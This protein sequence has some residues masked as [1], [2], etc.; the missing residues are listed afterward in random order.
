MNAIKA[1]SGSAIFAALEAAKVEFVVTVP[2]IVTSEHV[3]RPLSDHPRLRQ[4]KVCKE[5]EGISICA[6]LS[7]CER[8]ALLLIQHTGL[9]DSLNALRA[10]AVE[11]HLPICLMVGLQGKEAGVPPQQSERYGVRIVEPILDAMEVRHLL[12][13][14]AAQV[15]DIAPAI[16]AAYSAMAPVVML[17]GW[18]PGP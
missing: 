6:A 3:L 7:H 12:I 2:D 5:D 17:V 9:L 16:E 18:S 15:A 11:Y 4:V 10:I 8:R 1:P 14:E 13:E